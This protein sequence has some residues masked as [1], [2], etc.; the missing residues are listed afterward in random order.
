LKPAGG[1]S[2]EHAVSATRL[3]REDPALIGEN[4]S[5]VAFN[6]LLVPEHLIQLPLVR[7]NAALIGLDLLLVLEHL[8][9]LLLIRQH[10]RLIP[11]NLRLIRKYLPFAHGHSVLGSVVG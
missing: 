2:I 7:K 1:T 6:P 3:L 9:E 8:L 4:L 5:L 10:L 11:Q